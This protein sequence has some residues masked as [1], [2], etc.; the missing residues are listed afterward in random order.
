MM[1]CVW[2]GGTS[3]LACEGGD[4]NAKS[5][6]SHLL[7]IYGPNTVGSCLHIHIYCAMGR[8]T[9]VQDAITAG[10]MYVYS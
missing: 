5:D 4:G 7:L 3:L 9:G 10:T 2:V 6:R 8:D 1:K